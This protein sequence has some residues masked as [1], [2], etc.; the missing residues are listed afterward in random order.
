ML[1]VIIHK[2]LLSH[3]EAMQRINIQH[4]EKF[5]I[6]ILDTRMN[7]KIQSLEQNNWQQ[8]KLLIIPKIDT[9][10]PAKHRAAADR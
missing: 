3:N 5:L 7:T 9:V 10:S 8:K 2:L 1:N 4:L 6:T